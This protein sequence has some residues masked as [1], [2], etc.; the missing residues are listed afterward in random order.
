MKKKRIKKKKRHMKK[1]NFHRDTNVETR[2]FLFEV[3]KKKAKKAKS[4]ESAPPNIFSHTSLQS[5][6][7]SSDSC[8][9]TDVPSLSRKVKTNNQQYK[10]IQGFYMKTHCELSFL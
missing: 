1:V 10:E 5:D 3:K 9:G 7:N 2:K 6:P 8:S 4:S